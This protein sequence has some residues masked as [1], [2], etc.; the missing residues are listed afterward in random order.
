MR[1]WPGLGETGGLGGHAH[2]IVA[3]GPK[4]QRGSRS[5]ETGSP[6]E[7]YGVGECLLLIRIEDDAAA[8][9][10]LIL[11][12]GLF[13][14][15]SQRLLDPIVGDL[16]LPF[17]VFLVVGKVGAFAN[18]EVFVGH[19]VVVIGIDLQRLIERLQTAFDHR[20]VLLLELFLDLLVLDGAGI[21]LLHA[22]VG[23]GGA[24]GGIP[25]GPGDEAHAVIG[26][27]VLRFDGDEL[28]VPL[29]RLVPLF[30]VE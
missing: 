27:G 30:L 28:V 25:L 22:Q 3:G 21:F 13:F 15:L 12:F 2:S 11:L 18:Q 20:T 24:V 23:P 8:A 9:A 19:G 14:L 16:D 7:G 4:K 6:E 29:L 5:G 10:G 26:I 17:V 1:Y